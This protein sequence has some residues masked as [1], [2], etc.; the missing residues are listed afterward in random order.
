MLFGT[1]PC[2]CCNLSPPL[3]V[4]RRFC[5]WPASASFCWCVTTRLF[6]VALC[7]DRSATASPNYGSRLSSPLPLLV[8]FF[9]W[10]R[11]ASWNPSY[12]PTTFVHASL[13]FPDFFGCSVFRSVTPVS[14]TA[15]TALCPSLITV[16][17]E[18][19]VLSCVDFCSS[20]V[21][22]RIA[23]DF[24]LFDSSPWPLFRTVSFCSFPRRPMG[25]VVFNTSLVRCFLFRSTPPRQ[26]N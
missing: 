6:C 9:S 24:C 7:S 21:V 3:S 1:P 25:V 22:W 4:V 2:V 13:L 10:L 11:F 23:L 15:V 8:Y 12:L 5:E 18:S 17:G 19:A 20:R 16:D 14:G 26:M